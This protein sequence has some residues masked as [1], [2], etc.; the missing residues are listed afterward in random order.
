MSYEMILAL[1]VLVMGYWIGSD[2]VV[3]ALS[4]QRG[5]KSKSA[6]GTR[7]G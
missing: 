4:G 5:G 7:S 6:T 2:L 3:N 1:H